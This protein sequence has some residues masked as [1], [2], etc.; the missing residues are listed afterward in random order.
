MFLEGFEKVAAVSAREAGKAVGQ[1]LTSPFKAIGAAG[2]Q[3]GRGVRSAGRGFVE[4][5]KA[6]LPVKRVSPSMK[7]KPERGARLAR[8][9]VSSQARKGELRTSM[10]TAY[11]HEREAVEGQI[12]ERS[13]RMKEKPSWFAKHPVASGVGAYLG[14]K[15]LTSPDTGSQQ[16]PEP[17]VYKPSY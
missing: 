14:Y 11:K 9:H 16:T 4:G 2:V 7:F 12:K 13:K 5:A 17:Q 8:K 6:G 1:V 3:V 15:W 10:P